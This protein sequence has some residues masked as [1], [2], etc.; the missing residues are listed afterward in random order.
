MS[1]K[2]SNKVENE[3]NVYEVEVSVDAETFNDAVTKVYNKQKKNITVHGFRK[4]KAPRSVIEKLYG[5]GVF[6]DDAIEMVFPDALK[7]AVDEAGLD[8]VATEDAEVTSCGKDGLEIKVKVVVKPEVTISEY[9]GI[10]AKKESAEVTDEDIN[11]EIDKL[12]ERNARMVGVEDRAVKDGDFA[13]IDFEGFVDGVA[14]EGG[15]GENFNLGIGS[16][17]FIP[18]FEE[19]I[20][21]HNIGEEFDINV[22]FPENYN[23]KM[24]GKDATF[25]IKIKEIK[26]KELPEVD[27]EFV[28]DV[29]EFSTLDELKEDIKKHLADSKA[30]KVEEEFENSIVDKIVENMSADIP[31]AMIEMRIDENIKDF[32]YRLHAQGLG[33]DKY[34]QYTGMEMGAFRESFK[35]QAEKQVKT[36]LALEKIVELE[37]ITV[38]DA[39][40]E[41]EY[42]KLADSYN[43]DVENV[44]KALPVEMFTQDLKVNKAIDFVKENAIAE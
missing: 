30:H 27:D 8:M 40:V 12:R 34:L 28:K 5:E 35:E 39:T 11:A 4:G 41:E 14:F 20:I 7:A 24:A 16:G 1:L 19:Q 18:G 22:T 32:D 26:A 33:L 37:N 44:K 43:M 42:K 17:Q 23:P 21:G 9:K 36:R 29:S 3:N 15:K 10:K 31:N 38:D 6:Y 13:V 2:S 25:K